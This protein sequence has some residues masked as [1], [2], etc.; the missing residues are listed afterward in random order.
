M[1]VFFPQPFF[2]F[3]GAFLYFTGAG[4]GLAAGDHPEIPGTTS[5]FGFQLL[6]RLIEDEPRKQNFMISPVSVELALLMTYAGADGATATAIAAAAGWSGAGRER[7]LQ[8][9][10]ALQSSLAE[11]GRDVVLRI[12]NAVWVDDRVELNPQFRQET[13]RDFSAEVF[14]RPFQGPGIVPEINSW[15][16]QQTAGKIPK[17]V[18]TPPP[19]PLLLADAVYFKA[20]WRSRFEPHATISQPFYLEDKTRVDAMMMHQTASFPYLREDAFEAVRLPYAGDRFSLVLFLP[21]DGVTTKGLVQQLSERSWPELQDQFQLT[22]CEVAVPRFKVSYE[23]ALDQPLKTLG[24]GQAFDSNAADFRRMLSGTTP[25][26]YIGSVVHKTYL[27]VD[28]AGSE[29]AAA[30]SVGIRA[31]ALPRHQEIKIV[32]DRPFVLAISDQ[33]TQAVL[34]T[35]ILGNPEGARL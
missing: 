11:P 8:A 10:S 28:E 17:L 33:N 20:L 13:K 15:V 19:P 9:G 5:R 1:K 4:P 14:S 2:R 34:F 27:Q 18:A 3:V 32:F 30:T 21:A 29:A 22:A 12:A 7:I 6:S 16:N 25:R 24:M 23:T 26:L 31:L 35:G